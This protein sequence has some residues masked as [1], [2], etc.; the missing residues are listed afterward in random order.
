MKSVYRF[1]LILAVC[2]LLVVPVAFAQTTGTVDGTI[3]DQSGAALPGATVELTSPS[4]QGTRI[5][6]TSND[7][8][9]RFPSVPPGAYKVTASLSGFGKVQRSATVSLDSTATVAIQMSIST[10]AE[11]TVTG[12]APM[13]D[14]TSTTQGSSYTAKVMNKLPLGRNYA[15]IVFT[16][17]GVQA[18][19]GETQGRSLAISIY[20]STSSENLFLIDGVN[21][22]NVIKG[23]QGKDINGEFVQEVEVKTG[24]YQAEYGRNTGGVINVITK[25][26]GNEFHGGAFGYYSDAG[27]RATVQDSFA[28]PKFSQTGDAQFQNAI[29]SKD[30]RQE[31]GF[32]LGGFGLKDKVWFFGAY[33]RVQINQNVQTFDVNNPSTFGV[34]FPI[35]FVQNKY[36]AKVTVNLFQGT[37]IV[38]SYFSDTQTQTGALTTPSNFMT[39]FVTG[40]VPNS[41][42]STT[43]A[44]RRDTGGPDYG[45]R[46]N[47]L[48][49]SFGIFTF[50]YA[51]HSDRY[52]T[53]PDG[54]DLAGFRD[55]TAT[56]CPP[57]IEPATTGCGVNFTSGGGFGQIFGPTVNN[58]S[59][60][61]AYVGAFTGYVQ[62]H[63]IKVGGDYQTDLTDGTT[64]Y[65]GGQRVRVRPCLNA[66]SN[67]GA[68][69]CDLGQAPF[70]TNKNG[71]TYQVFYQHD[72]LANGTAADFNVIP[73][74]PFSVPTKRWSAFIQD[75]WRIIP[76]LT[77]NLGVR[78]DSEKY[79]GQCPAGG[80]PCGV[81]LNNDGIPD[82][83]TIAPG[84]GNFLAFS[85]TNQWAPRF[86]VVWDFTGDGTSKA[87]ASVGRFYYA[88]PTDLNVRIFTANSGISRF[89]YSQTS[90]D[91]LTPTCDGI[92]VTSACVPRNQGFQGGS[93]A[94]EPFDPG[95]K[96]AYQD[97]LTLGIE[98]SLDPT[99]SIGLK[100]TYRTLGR[101]VEDRCDLDSSVPI[102]EGGAPSSCAFYNPGGTGPAA[103]GQYHLCDGSGNPTDPLSGTCGI[104]VTN[105]GAVSRIF[106]GIELVARKQVG[107]ALWAQFS[108]LYSSLRGNYSGAIR[109]SSGQTDPGI[110]ADFDYY[111]FLQ[112][113]NG[114][115]ELD[116][117][118][119][120]RLDTVYNTPFG[121]SAG[122]QFYVRS[123]LPITKQGWFNDIYGVELFI[124]PRGSTGRTPT[125]YDMNLS[126]GWNLNVGPV[127]ITPMLYLYNVINRQV[128][129]QV[130][131]NFNPGASF[132]T[133]TA[134]PFYGQA[135]IEPGT[136][137]CP[138][139]SSTPCADNQDYFKT[140]S[141]GNPRL[142]RAALKIT[143]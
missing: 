59:S 135:G 47:Q 48:F 64:Y 45:A 113:A 88:I 82:P 118:V 9:Y 30:S 129:L 5:A 99:F 10:T 139:A 6:V 119:Q 13:V 1:S 131:N 35:D 19:F 114:K 90:T 43:Y 140:V 92:T 44:G 128:T 72:E 93:A 132:V 91:Q 74:S 40:G 80:E 87:Y 138:A 62:N 29:L 110:N 20:G 42:V 123:G 76:T 27:M 98:K 39:G 125:D 26:G 34:E 127:T 58:T 78:Y 55:Y 106:R 134:S 100:G 103:S 121:L 23:F 16:Q 137:N 130:D 2:V 102:S 68:S 12:D 108:F 7:G 96:A 75:Q 122:L 54:I 17:P 71:D 52:S 3:T 94:G 22:T 77:V 11:V 112:N 28:T 61:N 14:S 4:L 8:R 84:G 73:A 21:T 105:V 109:E 67:P 37:T 136:G 107:N 18:D 95:T 115:L 86:G 70:Y 15:Q 142:L 31:Y 60:R 25:S 50:Q 111:Q 33:N 141:R 49:G 51:K 53:K 126:L 79:Y 124:D 117:P 83:G 120:A 63:E 81:D 65:T 143:F 133:N 57:V 104:A 32:D 97:E 41:L 101:T 85:L 56:G 38:G 24:G 116:R 66:T 89:N 36:A 46:L 69:F